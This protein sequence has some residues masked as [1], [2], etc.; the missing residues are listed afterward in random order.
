MTGWRCWLAA[1]ALLVVGGGH[2]WAGEIRILTWSSYVS[3]QVLER[4]ERETGVRVKVDTVTNYVDLLAPLLTGASGYDIA[5]PADFQVRDLVRGGLL[6]KVGV[7]RLANFW[8]IEDVWRSRPLDPRDEYT[9][10][11]VWGT[12]AFVVDS[13][14]YKGDIDT[15]KLVFEPP[16]EIDGKIVL[17]D[18]GYD[19]VQL[20]LIWLR[21]PRCSTRPE[22]L[23]RAEAILL[24]MMRRYPLADIDTI[25]EALADGRY[26][27]G[28]AW[29]GDALKARLKRPSLKFAHPREGSLVWTDVMVVPKGAP[30][31]S[32]ALKFLSYMMRPDVAGMESNYN[33][34]ATV[35]K[36]VDRYLDRHMLNAPEIVAP[37][38]S[39]LDFFTFCDN[40]A[41]THQESYWK[42]L[43]DKARQ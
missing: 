9:V 15:L 6:E 17:L 31:R 2:G 26:V 25:V 35:I 39:T 22:H 37:I 21:L 32:D 41:E 16:P 14:V 1:L 40:N 11:H 24:P 38:S 4:F 5:F 20:A 36:G 13:S 30:N 29:N 28:V 12:T 42:A 33:L 7:D 18:S 27:L 8:N 3:P 43:K 34:Y 10:P 19:M 23:A